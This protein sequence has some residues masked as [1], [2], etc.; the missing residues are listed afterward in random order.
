MEEELTK[1]VIGCAI[2]AHRTLGG[3]GLME[4]VYEEALAYELQRARIE[5]QRQ[6]VL[7][8]KFK[9]TVLASPLRL[10]LVV[11]KRLIVECKA[12]IEYNSISEA[13]V[14]TYLRL[15][16]LKVGLVINFGERRLTDGVRRVANGF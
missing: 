13:Q 8:I 16:D 3:C 2:E 7:P 9:N 15:A 12:T 1:A 6:V 14:L 5:F 10:D 4:S 11:A